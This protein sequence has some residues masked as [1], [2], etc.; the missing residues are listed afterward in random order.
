MHVRHMYVRVALSAGAVE[1]TGSLLSHAS[2]PQPTPSVPSR[3]DSGTPTVCHSS[4]QR[5][6]DASHSSWYVMI[7]KQKTCHGGVTGV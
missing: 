2:Q 5:S 7:E 3:K 4:W 1:S 6:T